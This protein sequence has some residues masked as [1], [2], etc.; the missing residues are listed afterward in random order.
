M[1]M[2]D[3]RRFSIQAAAA[4]LQN[5]HLKGFFTGRI[6]Q[7]ASKGVCVPGLNCY[8]CPGAVG[9][10]PIG[11]LQSFLAARPIKLPY[12]VV[13]LLIFFGALL[14]RAVCGFL[15][16]FGFLQ[17]LLHR[18]PF[19]RR[20]RRFRGELLLR[21]LKYLILALLVVLP[22]FFALTPFFCKY[23]CPAGTLAGVL[24]ALADTAVRPL[25][26][27]LFAWK[28]AVLL[29]LAALSLLIWRPFCKYLCPLGAIYGLFNRFALYRG[30]LDASKCVRCGKCAAVCR[31]GVEPTENV[32]S[33]ECIR[34]GDCAR[35]CPTDAIRMGFLT[36]R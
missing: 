24:L 11:S 32:N 31:M 30:E 4:L 20:L 18:I 5:A 13:G 14:G 12:Y 28:A 8:S 15:C 26:G 7:G 9:A 10:C 29:A 1:R 19:P 35:A 23:L 3:K 34:C 21:K 33:A 27:G 17:E 36:R 6:Y 2:K 25:L 16:P 22:L